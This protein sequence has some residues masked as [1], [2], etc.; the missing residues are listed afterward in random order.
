MVPA[1]EPLP[2]K[3]GSF[4]SPPI[5]LSRDY[6]SLSD[7]CGG[8]RHAIVGIGPG[9]DSPAAQRGFVQ[10]EFLL[11]WMKGLDIPIL[12]TT[13]TL[14]G[15]GFLG[16][17]GTVPILGPGQFIG[18][19]RQGFRVRAGYWFDDCASCGING[20]FFFLG[21]Q[22]ADSFFSS[23]EF[24]TITR[25]V[26]SPNPGPG[27]GGVV[28]ETGEAV[29]VPGVLAGSLSAH[30]ESQL[31]GA[32]VNIQK[33]LCSGCDYKATWFVGYRNVNLTESLSIT[34]NI[35]VIAPSP[36]IPDPVGSVVAVNDRFAT[37]NHFHGAQLGGTYERRWGRL[38]FDVRA[39]V[40][41]GVTHEDLDISGFQIRTR[42][43]L[44]PMSFNG[45]LLAAGPNLGSFSRN[46]FSVVPEAT[47][48]LGYWLTPNLKL[49]AGYNFLF[50]SNVIRPGDQVDN[51]VDLTFVPNGPAVAAS[52]QL[53]PQ[54]LFRQSDLWVTGVQFGLEYRW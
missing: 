17:P 16:A 36:S 13:N 27:P 45:G 7:L 44:P 34:E 50:W 51:V 11:W 15:Q 47:L 30:A 37:E 28:G 14:G 43:G 29:A 25:P 54:A 39:S 2:G 41:L 42:P 46:Q 40:A 10:G 49:Y 33:C 4:G 31:W 5:R 26:F 21:R 18:P 53:R 8:L 1:G 24:P 19:F 20:S 6:P 32:D 9:D 23:K 3:H 12:A 35:Q 22:T 38:S 48:N 52:G